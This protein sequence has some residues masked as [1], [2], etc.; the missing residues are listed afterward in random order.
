MIRI[1]GDSG[2]ANIL[3]ARLAGA[4]AT[5]NP[6][7]YVTYLSKLGREALPL[8][9]QV[10]LNGTTNVT[11]LAAPGVGQTWDDI[12]VKMSNIDTAAVTF[13][14]EYY[15]GTTATQLVREPVAVSE[16]V[17]IN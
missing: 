8:T 1:E 7:C 12:E 15:D 5:S 4:I 9:A 17:T 2:T 3:R 11:L 6:R 13:I 14:L 16:T 10:A